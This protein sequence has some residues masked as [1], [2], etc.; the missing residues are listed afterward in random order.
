MSPRLPPWAAGPQE[1]LWCSPPVG[2]RRG[3]GRGR[4]V[5]VRFHRGKWEPDRSRATPL[6]TGP[7]LGYSRPFLKP[8]LGTG[9]WP[10]G[11]KAA[12]LSCRCATQPPVPS[13]APSSCS[14]SSTPLEKWPSAWTLTV[15][16]GLSCGASVG[17]YPP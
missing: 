14:V 16:L 15:D 10:R 17:E 12:L 2:V 5:G 7:E 9:C 8:P 6:L 11:L 13:A 3:P 4:K 1:T